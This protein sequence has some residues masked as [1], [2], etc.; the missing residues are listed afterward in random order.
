M[1]TTRAVNAKLV[2][3]Y[4]KY[5]KRC[6]KASCPSTPLE[7]KA[8]KTRVLMHNPLA[9]TRDGALLDG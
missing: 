4:L 8:W 1:K 3:H 9:L 7:Y 6:A 5:C 2:P